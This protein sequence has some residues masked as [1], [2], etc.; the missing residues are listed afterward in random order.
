MMNNANFHKPTTRDAR[1]F[2]CEA[3]GPY[4]LQ[5]G[6]AIAHLESGFVSGRPK[7]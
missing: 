4:L 2:A 1:S 6:T 7:N 3:D 5:V